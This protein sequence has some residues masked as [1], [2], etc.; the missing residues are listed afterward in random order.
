MA[1]IRPVQEPRIL[2]KSKNNNKIVKGAKQRS[3]TTPKTV[4]VFW[5]KERQT[6]DVQEGR[7]YSGGEAL[8][9]RCMREETRMGIVS[10]RNRT[11]V[12]RGVPFPCKAIEVSW[13]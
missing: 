13:Y 4:F 8:K 2:R 7:E 6:W 9:K 11:V 10:I 3:P 12:T 5:P 1:C